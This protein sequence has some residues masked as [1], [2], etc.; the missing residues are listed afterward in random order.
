MKIFVDPGHGGGDAGATFGSLREKDV[1]LGVGL[2]LC[3]SLER[4]NHITSIS[5]A[6]DYKVPLH[7]RARLANQSESDL[8]ISL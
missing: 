7:V 2:A 3:E 4:K 5:R 1:T 8:F 6:S